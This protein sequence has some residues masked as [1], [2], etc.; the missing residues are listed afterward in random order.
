MSANPSW[1][2]LNRCPFKSFSKPL[3]VNHNEFIIVPSKAINSRSDGIY[4]YNITQNRYIKIMDY[5]KDFICPC[6]DAI[7]NEKK[8][9]IYVMTEFGGKRRQNYGKLFEFDLNKKR[10]TC[11]R[12]RRCG[13]YPAMLMINDQ[14]NVIGGYDETK[15]DIWKFDKNEAWPIKEIFNFTEFSDGLQGHRLIHIKSNGIVLLFGGENYHNIYDSLYQYSVSHKVWNK[16][17]ISMPKPLSHFGIVSTRCERYVIILGGIVDVL[18]YDVDDSDDIFIYDTKNN[19]FSKS[20]VLCPK[21]AAYHAIIINDM[22]HDE[23][24]TFGYIRDC[25]KKDSF[26]DLQVLPPH[27]IRFILNWVCYEYIHLI[28]NQGIPDHSKINV[29]HIL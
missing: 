25:Y 9:L 24:L 13:R 22:D 20:N 28:E 14:I 26:A 15:H 29:D 16:L 11:L 1:I 4:K 19:S 8:Q 23:V 10:I 7:F 12:I 3:I 6:H 5:P 2:L 18:N 27:L 17:N 21:K